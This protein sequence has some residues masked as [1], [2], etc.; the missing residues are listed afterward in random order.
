MRYFVF[1]LLGLATVQC[2]NLL[3][4]FVTS[5]RQFS[6]DVYKK[7]KTIERGNFLFCPLSVEIILALTRVGARGNTGTQLSKALHLP[8]DIN[9]IEQIFKKLT[10]KLK[11]AEGY[12]LNSANR[13][14]LNN[15]YE[16]RKDFE[17]IAQNSFA[18]DIKNINFD[19]QQKA[20]SEINQWVSDQTHEKIKDLVDPN[21]FTTNT[22]SVLVNALYFKSTWATPFYKHA[23]ESKYFY[24]NNDDHVDVDM[25]EVTDRFKYFQ[26]DELK[27]Q[28][29]EMP[30]AGNQYSMVL[31]LPYEKEGLEQLENKLEDVLEISQAYEAKVHV[32]VP[33]FKTEF[34]VEL[35]DIL[36]NLGIKDLFEEDAELI[37]FTTSR[38]QVVKV[39]GVV[40]KA[41]IEVDEEGTTAAAATAV[42]VDIIRPAP[43]TPIEE[44]N[45]DHP[46]I[47]YIKGASGVMFIGRYVHK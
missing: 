22:R 27:A 36:K 46:F 1:F 37:A 14:Y 10:P 38:P 3:E 43:P 40:Q 20:A 8:N 47:Y 39:S 2:D 5:N 26:S 34:K 4:K 30:Y 29:L 44:F 12:T 23:T 18:A 24:L 21:S 33:K 7:I 25:M 32:Q 6:S 41:V 19:N 16:I 45:A 11:S 9:E 42:F 28:F 13:I 15:G 35:T 17:N 31:A